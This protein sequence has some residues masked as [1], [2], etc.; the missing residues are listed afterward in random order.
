MPKK[1]RI[2]LPY[3]TAA[4]IRGPAAAKARAALEG[5]FGDAAGIGAAFIER[6]RSEL[7]LFSELHA[8]DCGTASGY[9]AEELGRIGIRTIAAVDIDDYRA[10]EIRE[11]GLIR[12]FQTADL[13]SDPLPWPDASFDLVTAWCVLPHLENPFHFVREVARVLKPGGIFFWSMP[14]V[15]SLLSRKNF[16]RSGELERYSTKNNHIAI[17][18][19]ALVEKIFSPAF[20]IRAR[21]YTLDIAKLRQSRFGWLKVA[22]A[23]RV[24]FGRERFRAWF[25]TDILYACTKRDA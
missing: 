9:F 21:E 12:D 11:R 14:N 22:G 6:W 19:P 16:L 8:L 20:R 18:T 7:P 13:S 1:D 17:F 23:Q 25:G 4:E 3:L 5:H 15:A 24:W 2:T 10:S